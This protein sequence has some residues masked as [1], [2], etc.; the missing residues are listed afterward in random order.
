MESNAKHQLEKLLQKRK[1]SLLYRSLKDSSGLIDLCSNDYLGF[2]SKGILKQ[3]LQENSDS[4][5][6]KQQYG[7]TG[8]RLI[9]GN[10]PEHESLEQ[11]LSEFYQ[12]EAALLFNSGYDA[13]LGL[14][15]SLPQKNDLVLFDELCH[16]SIRDGLKMSRG[17]SYSFPHN[18]LEALEKMLQNALGKYEQVYVATETVFSMDGDFAPLQELVA[19]KNKYGFEIILD[20]AHATGI[21]GNKGQGRAVELN[22]YS[23][24]FASV[25]TFGKALGAHGAVVLGSQILKD[26]LIN[27]SRP[28]IFTT[29]L[30]LD[31]IIAIKTAHDILSNKDY[32]NNKISRLID[33]FKV[34]IKE[35]DQIT[36]IPSESQIQSVLIPGNERAKSLALTLERA[37]IYAKAILYPTVPKGKERIRICLHEFNTEAEIDLLVNTLKASL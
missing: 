33:L 12:R 20:E 8:S 9:S 35:L 4:G 31:S 3:A 25:H 27:F 1:D 29:A 37:G 34:K 16:A 21:F 30:P 2:S 18:D 22:L 14:Y 19:L 23:E 28:F 13:N 7:A 6:A 5:I 15:S 32:N 10:T 36:L 11:Y 24:I 17:E 26:F